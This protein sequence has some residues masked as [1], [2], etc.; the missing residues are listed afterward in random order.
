MPLLRHNVHLNSALVGNN[1]SLRTRA[2]QWGNK[3]QLQWVLKELDGADVDV[4]LASELVYWPELFDELIETLHGL[5]SAT[6]I[7]LIAYEE[8]SA[9]KERKFFDTLSSAFEVSEVPS[10]L[11]DTTYQAPELHLFLAKQ[12]IVF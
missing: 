8:R 2:M 10:Q 3:Q 7:V 4:V 11:L 12:R 6:T 1:V 5:C 9:E